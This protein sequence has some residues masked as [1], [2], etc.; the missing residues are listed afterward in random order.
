MVIMFMTRR[1]AARLHRA[2]CVLQGY[3]FFNAAVR[4]RAM[5]PSGR[6]RAA[7][8]RPSRAPPRACRQRTPTVGADKAGPLERID[9]LAEPRPSA[10][11]LACAH[12]GAGVITAGPPPQR[13]PAFANGAAADQLARDNTGAWRPRAL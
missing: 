1:T 9:D 10:A 7:A 8:T 4:A 3:K 13:S 12:G 5:R 11:R 6:R 2:R